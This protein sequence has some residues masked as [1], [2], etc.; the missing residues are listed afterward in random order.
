MELLPNGTGGPGG[1]AALA[2]GETKEGLAA[3]KDEQLGFS[4]N[5]LVTRDT[6]VRIQYSAPFAKTPG[7]G[8]AGGPVAM[9]VGSGFAQYGYGGGGHGMAGNVDGDIRKFTT[10]LRLPDT[11]RVL[12]VSGSHVPPGSTPPPGLVGPP[13]PPPPQ[14][15]RG[16]APGHRGRGGAGKGPSADAA[17]DKPIKT[18]RALGDAAMLV[19]FSFASAASLR[20]LLCIARGW[21][22][23]IRSHPLLRKR[24][25]EFEWDGPSQHPSK[26]GILHYFGT[27]LGRR[28]AWSNPSKCVLHSVGL[29]C[30][31]MD[32]RASASVGSFVPAV[33]GV[34]RND[35][36][37]V[38]SHGVSH[39]ATSG[40]PYSWIALDFKEFAV[41]PTYYTFGTST[42]LTCFPTHWQLLGSECDGKGCDLNMWTTW[43][44]LDDVRGVD[45][46]FGPNRR[47]ATFAVKNAA[48][49]TA[50]FRHFRLLQTAPNQQF[51]HTLLVSGFEVFGHLIRPTKIRYQH[52]IYWGV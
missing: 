43:V 31:S 42:E 37:N 6:V 45:P 22:I 23:L 48:A 38:V 28:P 21:S 30:S 16:L 27:A 24:R 2:S 26:S 15:L 10:S 44:L 4:L 9:V 33:R 7:T 14:P 47:T 29:R 52:D 11:V 25:L 13:R 41:S 3:V 20:D 5:E 35:L 36:S 49:S 8:V 51:G 34:V 12:G 19:I 32:S 1:V 17:G 50:H 46:P 18:V 39:F 40:L